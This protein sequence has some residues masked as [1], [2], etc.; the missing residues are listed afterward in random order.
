MIMGSTHIKSTCN[1][2]KPLTLYFEISFIKHAVVIVHIRREVGGI[3]GEKMD[4]YCEITKLMCLK[5]LK[6]NPL[7]SSSTKRIVRSTVIAHCVIAPGGSPKRGNVD[8]AQRKGGK[9]SARE[10]Q[11]KPSTP[12][13][14]LLSFLLSLIPHEIGYD[15]L[16][17]DDRPFSA[18]C[19]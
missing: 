13:L 17:Q 5:N 3:M 15:R 1:R 4:R 10:G 2:S 9:R 11:I 19:K 12:R 6:P 16:M 14:L 18:G 8:L 7:F